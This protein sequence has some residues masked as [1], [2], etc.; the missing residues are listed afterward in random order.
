MYLYLESKQNTSYLFISIILRLYNHFGKYWAYKMFVDNLIDTVSLENNSLY[1]KIAP[2]LALDNI[3]PWLCALSH[4]L[5]YDN[6]V[7][8]MRWE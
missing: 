4:V 7:Y 3:R 6:M 2:G 5:W 8:G 1:H